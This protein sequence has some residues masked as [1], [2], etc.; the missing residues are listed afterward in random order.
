MSQDSAR[1]EP[2]PVAALP[3]S[4]PLDAGFG[5]GVMGPCGG[6]MGLGTATSGY[7]GGLSAEMVAELNKQQWWQPSAQCPPPRLP[8][9]L[10][11]STPIGGTGR[12]DV[13]VHEG[14]KARY[15]LAANLSV[16]VDVHVAGGEEPVAESPDKQALSASEEP[17]EWEQAGDYKEPDAEHKKAGELL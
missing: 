5:G 17:A 13:G 8:E 14:A 12:A 6:T 11:R 4:F 9:H 3:G 15:F 10:R 16:P 2:R 7:G 1:A